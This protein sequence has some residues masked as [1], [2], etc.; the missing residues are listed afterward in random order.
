MIIAAVTVTVALAATTGQPVASQVIKADCDVSRRGTLTCPQEET[1][2][3]P[4]ESP[5]NRPRVPRPS[6]EDILYAADLVAR[7]GELCIVMRRVVF[8]GA[9]QSRRAFEEEIQLLRLMGQYDFCP[10]VERP[11]RSPAVVARSVVEEFTP[12]P[13]RP[14][15]AP[16]YAITGKPAYLETNGNLAPATDTRTT[17]LGDIEVTFRGTYTVDWGDGTPVETHTAEGKPWPDGTIRHT[18]THTGHYDVVVTANWTATWRIGTTTGEITDGL[19]T[20]QTIE[21]FEVRQLQAVRNH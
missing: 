17:E 10:G 1:T 3:V 11:V 5:G 20:T 9:A 4:G 2:S 21:D 6:P 13:P 14:H 8:P 7:D 19:T 15:I 18:Y 16:G 12:T